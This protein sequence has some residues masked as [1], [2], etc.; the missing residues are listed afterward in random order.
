M[1]ETKPLDQESYLQGLQ[2][3]IE[4]NKT[5]A[6]T[7]DERAEIQAQERASA[8]EWNDHNLRS[9]QRIAKRLAQYAQGYALFVE[10]SGW[11]YWTGTHWAPDKHQA[12]VHEIL[13]QLLKVSWA[14]AMHDKELQADVRSAMTASGSHGVIELASRSSELFAS[15]VDQDPYLLNCQ[16]GTLDLHTLQLRPHNPADRI[17]KITAAAY[18]PEAPAS[19]WES[20]LE[21]SLPDP[22]VRGFMQRYAGLSLI[23][24]VIEHVMLIAT[25]TGRNGKGV[26]ARTLSKALGDY[27]V[28]ATNDLLVT[29]R[30]GGKSAGELAAQMILRGARFAVMSE[31][32]KND[33]MN[34]TLLKSLTGGDE[35]TAK[36]MGQNY[37][38]FM[39]SHSFFLQ[40]NDL[41]AMDADAKA[42]WA[43]VRVVP[44][45][46]SF[47]GREDH[48][49]EERLEAELAGVLTWAVEGLRAYQQT[50][51]DEPEAVLQSTS[52]YKSENDALSRFIDDRCVTGP[53]FSVT[54]AKLTQEYNAWAAINGEAQ[55][56]SRALGK[57]V[58][59]LPGINDVRT[60]GSRGLGGIGLKHECD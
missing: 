39:P 1:A 33:R 19:S 36:L 32:D 46:V 11:H 6:I 53:A 2:D 27:A 28:T 10:G 57:Q 49:L 35:I 58:R 51:L 8:I 12:Q 52:A 54:T 41:P 18:D 30:H 40:T 47:E 31:L 29:G 7:P 4:A 23:G 42:A 20:F 3:A 17:T 34:E 44:F 9:H 59:Q 48:G 16:N 15:Q 56:S 13:S 60:A 22:A 38:S 26:L 45:D 25:G 43:R 37:V 55:L 24:R 14:E 5:A 21:S 50:G